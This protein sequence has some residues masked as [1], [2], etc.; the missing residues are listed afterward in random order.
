MSSQAPQQSLLGKAE[1]EMNT[2]GQQ[3][4]KDLDNLRIAPI[5]EYETRINSLGS[6]FQES[7]QAAIRNINNAFHSSDQIIDELERSLR[8]EKAHLQAKGTL[9]DSLSS[10][11][12]AAKTKHD[13]MRAELDS[14]KGEH[15]KARSELQ[16][17]Q[18]ELE[19][20]KG[21]PADLRK[22]LETVKQQNIDLSAKFNVAEHGRKELLKEL[23]SVRQHET[24]IAAELETAKE[25]VSAV[26]TGLNASQYS[27]IRFKEGLDTLVDSYKEQLT[28]AR[29]APGCGPLNNQQDSVEED[30]WSAARL[31]DHGSRDDTDQDQK[32]RGHK[33]KASTERPAPS[34]G[35]EHAGRTRS[36]PSPDSHLAQPPRHY[37]GE[38]LN[39]RQ[40]QSQQASDTSTG[41]TETAEG[42]WKGQVIVGHNIQVDAK[43]D[44]VVKRATVVKPVNTFDASC[45]DL[46]PDKLE[47]QGHATAG[48]VEKELRMLNFSLGRDMIT[49]R[50]EPALDA[51]S[52]EFDRLFE[53][54]IRRERYGTVNH[55]GG[56]NVDK[57]YLIPVPAGSQYPE[58]ISSLDYESL[59]GHKEV[60]VLLLVVLFQV[61]QAAQ[62]QI[63]LA[64]D[65]AIKAVRSPDMDDLAGVR[66]H[67]IHHP[68]PVFQPGD[69]VVSGSER[70]MPMLNNIS[71]SRTPAGPKIAASPQGFFR[72][73]CT[74]LAQSGQ[75]SIDGVELPKCIFILGRVISPSSCWSLLVVD[76]EHEDRPLWGIMRNKVNE[77]KL[78]RV[79][80]LMRSQFPSSLDEWASTIT[81]DHQ[82]NQLK[83]RLQ[84]NGLKIE[85]YGGAD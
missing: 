34:E 75:S 36:L 54:F 44:V 13:N 21:Q 25:R 3:F 22:A 71:C 27:F 38:R 80:M 12:K 43:V 15:E 32:S 16:K 69:F 6:T 60:K 59:P 85:R 57:V 9:V 55:A 66:N 42:A 61:K 10:D 30:K 18:T 53:Y 81:M 77:A 67:L 62:E 72:L 52:I 35:D 11:L 50:I 23:A 63:R 24:S 1:A 76:M 82:N 29:H 84:L 68:L 56:H 64:L 79:M 51:D 46:F 8:A 49:F 31:P 48:L 37:S 20:A 26:E 17:A 83:K 33:R 73:S 74:N 47:V 58:Y 2:L 45:M 65:A 41:P 19:K 39:N 14:A 70:Y 7:Q 5:I 4:Q 40:I 78:G 28:Q